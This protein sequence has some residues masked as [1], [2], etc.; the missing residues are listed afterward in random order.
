MYLEG[1]NYMIRDL[2]YESEKIAEISIANTFIKRMMG[3]MFRKKPHYKAIM[4][5]PCNSIHSFFMNFEIDILFV[6]NNMEIIKKIEGLKP[7]KVVLPVKGAKMVIEGEAGLFKNIEEGS[8]IRVGD[9]DS[10]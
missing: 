1:I 3:Y 7:G 5:E 6:N 8:K 2:V 10:P 9:V 4:I